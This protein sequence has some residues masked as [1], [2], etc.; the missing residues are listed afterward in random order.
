LTLGGCRL[1]LDRSVELQPW[2]T[3]EVA[4]VPRDEF[5]V[6]MDRRRGDEQIEIFDSRASTTKVRTKPGKLGNDCR[7]HGKNLVG[8]E[9]AAIP[10]N[11]RR[12]VGIAERSLE[13]LALGH[14]ANR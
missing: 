14:D 3:F 11:R 13:D 5:E 6:V 2:D 12:R 7:S 4:K 1:R 10:D 9:E 8:F